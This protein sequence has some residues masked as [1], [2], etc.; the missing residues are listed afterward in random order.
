M[1]VPGAGDGQ[2]LPHPPQLR[3]SRCRSLQPLGQLIWPTGQ[4]EQSVLA[5]L[6]APLVHVMVAAMHAPAVEHIAGSVSTPAAH[7]WPA[8]HSVP[9]VLLVVSTHVCTPVV[10]DVMPF[11]H[12]FAGW[13]A[14][15][16]V[17]EL[18]LP[19][20]H[21]RLVPHGVP[22]A[23]LVPASVHMGLPVVHDN[24]PLWQGLLAGAHAPPATHVAQ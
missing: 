17:H 7:D 8:P 3:T 20:M 11:L 15:P 4:V 2:T 13:Q 16:A 23:T 10:H 22:L 24:V 19:L 14:W 6:H 1:P 12:G 21:T 9:A 18:Q 5:V